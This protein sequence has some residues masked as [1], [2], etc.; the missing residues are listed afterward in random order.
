MTRLSERALLLKP[1]FACKQHE[2]LRRWQVENERK[3]IGFLPPS[4]VFKSETGRTNPVAGSWNPTCQ[5]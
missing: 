3:A 5:P 4:R 1:G 2:V